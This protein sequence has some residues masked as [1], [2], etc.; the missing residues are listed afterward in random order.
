[1]KKKTLRIWILL[2]LVVVLAIGC[3]SFNKSQ[4]RVVAE[5]QRMVNEGGIDKVAANLEVKARKGEVIAVA[6]EGDTNIEQEVDDVIYIPRTLEL[7]TP[8]LAVIPL[9]LL[10]YHMA[11]L[12]GSDVDQPR[13][14]AKSVTVE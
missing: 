3:A 5:Q 13:N 11:V 12:R 9:Q 10:A 7:L 8:I 4:T 2:P 1:M 14:L 6:N